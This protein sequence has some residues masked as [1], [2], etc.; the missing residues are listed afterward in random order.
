MFSHKQHI[1]KTE[2]DPK[3][4]FANILPK[5]KH[6]NSKEQQTTQGTLGETNTVNN[7]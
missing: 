5:Q 1:G 6:E 7:Y 4:K 2:P 3:Q